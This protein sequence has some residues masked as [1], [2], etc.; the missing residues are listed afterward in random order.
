M[1]KLGSQK[2]F[3]ELGNMHAH[4]FQ[5]NIMKPVLGLLGQQGSL[6]KSLEEAKGNGD[7][8]RIN[9]DS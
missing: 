2:G 8:L 1:Y 3:G 7:I 5:G 6:A 4:F 9:R